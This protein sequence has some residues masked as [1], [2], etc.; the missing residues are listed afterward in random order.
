VVDEGTGQTGCIALTPPLHAVDEACTADAQCAAGQWCEHRTKVCKHICKTTADCG[1]EKCTPG[2]TAQS[3]K[4][5]GLSVCV[6]D[7]D[8]V[9][10]APCGTGAACDYDTAQQIKGLDCFASG[11]ALESD[12]CADP[13]ECAPGLTCAAGHC[14]AW[15]IS[16]ADCFYV[17]DTCYIFVSYTPSHA[18]QDYGWCGP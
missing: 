5:T 13:W 1:G 4:I 7:C 16:T 3:D 6:V 12:A 17:T 10:T 9:N 18:G 14:R 11:N 2:L 8:P 15:C